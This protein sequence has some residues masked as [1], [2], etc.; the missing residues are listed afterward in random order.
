MASKHPSVLS[1]SC[2]TR[3]KHVLLLSPLCVHVLFLNHRAKGCS[4]ISQG[5]LELLRDKAL[6]FKRQKMWHVLLLLLWQYPCVVC[7]VAS[8]HTINKHTAT[9]QI[10]LAQSSFYLDGGNFLKLNVFF[11][12]CYAEA[13]Y[14]C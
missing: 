2:R 6:H 3:A 13:E 4:S 12:Y 10:K 1:G 11:Q 8:S 14:A 7:A 5:V 9:T